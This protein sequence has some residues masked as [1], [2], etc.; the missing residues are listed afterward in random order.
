[1]NCRSILILLRENVS[2]RYNQLSIFMGLVKPIIFYGN[3]IDII[4]MQKNNPLSLTVVYQV[5]INIISM[6]EL[7]WLY[8]ST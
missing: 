3:T 1:M 6:Y 7:M 2:R 5:C 4:V 8:M